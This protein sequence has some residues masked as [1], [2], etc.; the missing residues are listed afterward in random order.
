MNLPLAWDVSVRRDTE[1]APAPSPSTA[2]LSGSPPKEAI[3]D[4]THFS[5]SN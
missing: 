5:A 4:F 1:A 2:T 3:F